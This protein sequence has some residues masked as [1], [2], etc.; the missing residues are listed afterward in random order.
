MFEKDMIWHDHNQQAIRH[1]T[2]LHQQLFNQRIERNKLSRKK[3]KNDVE[4]EKHDD[5]KNMV[6][7]ERYHVMSEKEIPGKL[8]RDNPTRNAYFSDH[9]M[10]ACK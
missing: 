10:M 7:L 4:K 2:I 1:F 9:A 3:T 8:K 5:W 6:N